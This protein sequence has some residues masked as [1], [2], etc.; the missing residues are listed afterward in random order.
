MVFTIQIKKEIIMDKFLK[1]IV[2]LFIIA[3]AIYLAIIWNKL[4]EKVAIHFNLLGNPDRYGSKN[5]L[6][7]GIAVLMVV[8]AAIWL[9]MPLVYKIDR[10]KRAVENKTRLLR[11]AFAISIFI[12]FVACVVI[13]S[14]I[15]DTHFNVRIIF[16]SIGLVWCIMGNYMHNIKPNHFAG[17]RNS[18][19][20]NNEE[21]WRK[22]HLLG[23]KI[24][25]SGGL[26]VAI[27]SFFAPRNIAII[28]LVVV[29]LL[30]I[31]I[32]FIY[33]YLLYKNRKALNSTN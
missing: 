5:G 16:G 20:L 15:Y 2:W 9:L 23:S 25:F 22:T 11:M 26:L 27:A 28:T 31:L 14:T 21:N 12:S 3:P 33:S 18:W 10:K 19:T 30:I 1:K 32:P 24:W 4:P 8:A 13:N 17:F 7:I 6:I 29:S